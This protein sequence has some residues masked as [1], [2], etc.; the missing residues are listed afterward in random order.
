MSMEKNLPQH[1]CRQFV[2]QV[3]LVLDGELSKEEEDL[4]IRDIKRCRHCLEHYNI[5]KEFKA[6][7][8]KSVERK[9]CSE[10]LKTDIISQIRSMSAGT[11]Q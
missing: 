9:Q 6:Y 4:F 8:Q 5:E 3:F 2:K 10:K 1:D 11:G 7:L